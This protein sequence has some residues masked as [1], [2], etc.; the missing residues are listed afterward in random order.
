[1]INTSLPH[2]PCLGSPF[3]DERS[4]LVCLYMGQNYLKAFNQM[5]CGLEI[6]P[7]SPSKPAQRRPAGMILWRQWLSKT[8]LAAGGTCSQ[9]SFYSSHSTSFQW[10]ATWFLWSQY[11]WSKFG[12]FALPPEWP[13]ICDDSSITPLPAELRGH[14]TETTERHGSWLGSPESSDPL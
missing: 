9:G 1:M 7:D 13:M 6:H 3:S 12:V 8:W 2:P 11:G 14:W 10:E 5:T 4:F